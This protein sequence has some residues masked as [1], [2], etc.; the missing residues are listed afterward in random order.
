MEKKKMGRPSLG[1][2]RKVSITLPEDVWK[3]ID[4][5]KEKWDNT[6]S[7]TLRNIIEVYFEPE[8]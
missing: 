8:E 2:T 3:L 5:R 6:L 7:Q 1:E 4:E